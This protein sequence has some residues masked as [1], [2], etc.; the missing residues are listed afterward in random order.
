[1]SRKTWGI[2]FVISTLLLIIVVSLWYYMRDISTPPEEQNGTV[3]VEMLPVE[4]KPGQIESRFD[5]TNVDENQELEQTANYQYKLVNDNNYVTVYQLP[6]NELYEYTDV[7]MDVLPVEL[8]EEIH[9]GKYLKDERELY[10]F[11]EN[12]TS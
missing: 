10:N 4:S 11:L 6:E 5:R 7:I 8:Q 1:M 2:A 3:L 9:N 12:Y